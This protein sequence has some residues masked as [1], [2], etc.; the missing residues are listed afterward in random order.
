MT[1]AR[2][3]FLGRLHDLAGCAEASIDLPG[4]T[5]WPG[6]QDILAARFGKDLAAAVAEPR[7]S[8]AVHGIVQPHRE[9]IV[10]R[11]GDEIAFLP[12]V[13]GG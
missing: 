9:S 10:M 12:P 5:T 13:S 3:V 4:E 2:F 7:T 6:L 11:P 1:T 8:V